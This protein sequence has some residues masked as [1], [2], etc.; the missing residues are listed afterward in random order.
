MIKVIWIESNA[1]YIKS[2]LNVFNN[3]KE[4]IINDKDGSKLYEMIDK[5]LDEKNNNIIINYIVDENLTKSMNSQMAFNRKKESENQNNKF[6]NN[7]KNNIPLK[8]NIL[9]LKK[10]ELSKK[11]R[12]KEDLFLDSLEIITDIL[13]S[14]LH[15]T[16][17]EEWKIFDNK[18]FTIDHRLIV[19]K[20][21]IA[22]RENRINEIKSIKYGIITQNST[23]IKISDLFKYYFEKSNAT[24]IKSEEKEYEFTLESYK[25]IHYI[26]RVLNEDSMKNIFHLYS[27]L[28]FFLI[29]IDIQ[30]TVALKNLKITLIN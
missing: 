5:Q 8:I 23:L 22:I 14:S 17:N 20:K 15:N 12:E 6:E 25:D 24:I 21:I 13:R 3:A 1:N 7:F 28:N 10:S 30:S 11:E 26:F 2:I 4:I 29:F 9:N 19:I 18:E 16:Q 27:S